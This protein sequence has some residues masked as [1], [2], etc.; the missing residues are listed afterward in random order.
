MEQIQCDETI[1]GL[2]EA[3]R[4]CLAFPVYVAAVILDENFKIPKNI[5]IRDRFFF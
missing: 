4:G 3:G 5:V 1:V 2:D